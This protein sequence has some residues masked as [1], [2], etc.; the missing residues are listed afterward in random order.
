MQVQVSQT[1]AIA[2]IVFGWSLYLR[3]VN[4]NSVMRL[5][6]VQS[7]YLR[8]CVASA[9]ATNYRRDTPCLSTIIQWHIVL[10]GSGLK[11]IIWR[12]ASTCFRGIFD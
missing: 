6:N 1:I 5:F 12:H 8:S 3:T 11:V 2:A 10:I 4:A 7:D 9:T